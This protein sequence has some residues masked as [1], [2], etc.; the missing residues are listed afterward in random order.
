MNDYFVRNNEFQ[1]CCICAATY[2][3]IGKTSTGTL[4][5]HIKTKH[6]NQYQKCIQ[7]TL[8]FQQINPY[9]SKENFIKTKVM[10]NW[11]IMSLQPFSVVE[12]KFFVEMIKGFDPR[13]Q[14][15]CRK[16]IKNQIVKKFTKQ[17]QYV[18]NH[19]QNVKNKIS[20]TTDIWTSENSHTSFLGVTCHYVDEW[21]LKHFLLDIIPFHKSHNTENIVEAIKTLLVE[22]GISSKVLGITTDNASVMIAFGREI[23]NEL[24][25]N[26]NNTHVTHQR[27][28][29]HIL[30]I[31]VKHGLQVH[32]GTIEKVRKFM[33][34]IRNS[35]NLMEDF[36]R[37]FHSQ[38]IEFLSPQLDVDTRWNS[39]YLMLNKMCQIKV[40]ANMLV[41]QHPNILNNYNPD[42][43]D[44]FKINVSINLQ[45]T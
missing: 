44:W 6:P 14:I 38:S 4:K 37:I 42:E 2:S 7:T 26:H 10:I 1:K 45:N 5:N 30:N 9:T 21:N 24:N 23:K 33:E 27:C 25:I 12:D 41:A 8:N 31:A 32:D 11:I 43:D 36:K 3:G 18:K 19:I 34:K 40:Q 16:Y 39:T 35:V 13:Y 29:A 28:G 17:Q 15:P 22:L 20:L